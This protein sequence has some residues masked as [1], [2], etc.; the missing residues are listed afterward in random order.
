MTLILSVETSIRGFA[1]GIHDL[2]TNDWVWHCFNDE[3]NASNL[4]FHVSQG[5]K[6]ASLQMGQISGLTVGIGPG[7]FT[8]IKIGLAFC[9]GICLANAGIKILGLKTLGLLAEGAEPIVLPITK[10]HAYFAQNGDS[11]LIEFA[12]DAALLDKPFRL[13]G[14]WEPLKNERSVKGDHAERI[15]FLDANRAALEA[16][17]QMAQDGWKDGF[18][19]NWPSP[20]YM[21]LSTAEEKIGKQVS[22]ETMK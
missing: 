9:Y 16:H 14:D 4:G 17:K 12:K 18:S 19:D 20:N 13:I 21:R 8:G 6:D 3:R 11:R 7:S 22:W 10:T 15:E 1:A 2:S 5:L